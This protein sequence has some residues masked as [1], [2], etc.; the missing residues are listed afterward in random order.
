MDDI[1][2]ATFID[3]LKRAQEMEESM[4][5]ML[6]ELCGP[7]LTSTKLPKAMLQEIKKELLKIQSDT[8][9]HKQ[10]VINLLRDNGEA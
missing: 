1:I 8:D 4:A 7:A 9:R 5:D 3:G 2:K 10:T 6:I